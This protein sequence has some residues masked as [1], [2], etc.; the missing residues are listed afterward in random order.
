VK[1]GATVFGEYAQGTRYTKKDAASG[2]Y[3]RVRPE[4]DFRTNTEYGLLRT[5]LMP[6]FNYRTGGGGEPSSSANNQGLNV[7]GAL[8]ENYKKQTQVN[9]E[10]WVQLGGFLAGRTFSMFSPVGPTSNIGLDGR[11][12]RD[13]TNMFAYTM[14]FGNGVTATV[15]AED[16]ASQARDGVLSTNGSAVGTVTYGGA[17]VPDFVANLMVDQSWGKVVASG[18]VHQ[19]AYSSNQFSTDYGY[20]GQVAAKINLPMLANG[21][22][23]YLSGIYTNGANGYSLRNTAGDRASNGTADFGIGQVSASMNDVVVNTANGQ[24]SKATVM[25]GSA[26]FGHYFTPSVMVYAGGSY[27]KLSWASSAK[28]WDSTGKI[29]NPGSI[30]R[31][32][33][34]FQWTPI[35]GFVVWPEVEYSKVNLKTAVSNTTGEPAK[36]SQD[37]WTGRIQVKRFF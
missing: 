1:I 35:K 8:N 28:S 5:M 33:A 31:L 17:N 16:G 30:Y 26:E 29:I 4:L 9:V 12:Q 21:D 7:Q 18:A 14:S 22:Y 20:A 6:S 19:I 36:K 2:W 32:D 27:E 23:F 3:M 10:G 15:A 24:T 25:G 11:D 13:Q 34:G 37:N